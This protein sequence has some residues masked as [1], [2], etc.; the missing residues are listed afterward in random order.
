LSSDGNTRS[1]YLEFR[2]GTKTDDENDSHKIRHWQIMLG[3]VAGALSLSDGRALGYAR[4]A[5]ATLWY[6]SAYDR[7]EERPMYCPNCAAQIEETQKY[8]RSCGTDVNLVS[9][10]L[11]GQLP[12]MGAG[13]MHRG[14]SGRLR[15]RR[16]EDN[17]T[18]SI[19]RAV[20]AFFT[21]LGFLF[22]SLAAREF[23]PAGGIWWFW[24]LIPAFSCMGAGIG[25][26]LKLREQRWQRQ[27][28]QFDSMPGQPT[29]TSPTTRM[30]EISAPTTS[31]PSSPSSVTE[32]TTKHLD[33]SRSN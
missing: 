3:A 2:L 18:P 10:A 14:H 29:F 17:K 8:C 30:P 27:G 23:A 6:Y 32:H 28:S 13:G 5:V 25:Q 12:S 9:Q 7:Q 19:E 11:K 21:G 1:F 20:R 22:V 15:E 26:F 4:M 33:P 24:L 31:D 16:R